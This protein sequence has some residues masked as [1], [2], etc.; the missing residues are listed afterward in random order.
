MHLQTCSNINLWYLDRSQ[1]QHDLIHMG[2]IIAK[3]TI[4]HA[5]DRLKL[6][7]GTDGSHCVHS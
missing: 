5:V 1:V 3:S 2:G 6:V 4:Q 7:V